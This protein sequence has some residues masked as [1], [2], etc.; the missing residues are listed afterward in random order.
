MELSDGGTYICMGIAT[1]TG[2]YKLREL[3]ITIIGEI[4]K[5]KFQLNYTRHSISNIKF[6]MIVLNCLRTRPF[7]IYKCFKNFY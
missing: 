4:Q 3:N 6:H 1:S 2:E 7:I 5:I